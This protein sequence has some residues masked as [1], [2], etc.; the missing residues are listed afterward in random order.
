MGT[1]HDTTE[2]VTA[3]LVDPEGMRPA[4][5]RKRHPRPHL[6][7]PI[8]HQERATRSGQDL[9]D[10]DNGTDAKTPWRARPEV[11]PRL[12]ST[13]RNRSGCYYAVVTHFAG[14]D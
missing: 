12:E 5:T 6:S 13:R 11:T 7:K 14:A 2:N 9:N 1:M 3:E 4:C 8:G 10:E